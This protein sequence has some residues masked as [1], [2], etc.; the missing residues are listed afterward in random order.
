MGHR[1]GRDKSYRLSSGT[2]PAPI[3]RKP[4][5]ADVIRERSAAFKT[6]VLVSL[7]ALVVLWAFCSGHPLIAVFIVRSTVWA[8]WGGRSVTVSK[9]DERAT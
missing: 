5:D 4:V 6:Y 3:F 1:R 7:V 2:S 8:A 9:D